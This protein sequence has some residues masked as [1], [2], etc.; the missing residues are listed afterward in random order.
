MPA[1]TNAATVLSVFPTQLYE[2]V[3]ALAMFFILWRLR[4][5]RHAE[6]WLFGLYAV[7]SGLE[8]F[9]IEFYRAKDDR[10]VAGLTYAQ[11]I[12]V[13][14]ILIGLVIMALRWRVGPGRHGIHA[15][16]DTPA[17]A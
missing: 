11:C 15:T 3:L 8:R 6:G 2:V 10:L 14:F 9:I 16:A 1:G 17:A 4:N 7:F 5:H 13:G 12:A